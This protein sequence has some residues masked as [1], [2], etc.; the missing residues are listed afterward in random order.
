MPI[1]P[2]EN[3]PVTI[4]YHSGF[5]GGEEPVNP[6]IMANTGV[7]KFYK[8]SGSIL[9]SITAN[10]LCSLTIEIRISISFLL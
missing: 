4:G 9:I 2:L 3:M 7:I 5:T 10:I 8:K 6:E 1:Y